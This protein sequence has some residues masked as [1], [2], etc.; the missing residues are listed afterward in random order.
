MWAR[1]Y[2]LF[3]RLGLLAAF[4]LAGCDA[5]V[6][7]ELT[8]PVFEVEAGERVAVALLLPLGAEEE[9]WRRAANDM[10]AAAELALFQLNQPRLALLVKNS[11]GEAAQARLAAREALDEGAQFIIGPVL[12]P[13][14]AAVRQ[15]V[16]GR[17]PV[18]ALSGNRQAGEGL[19]LLGF[20]PEQEIARIISF[21]AQKEA[22][23]FAGFLPRTA[24]GRLARQSMVAA[25]R[26]Q[27]EVIAVL[28]TYPPE[29]EAA[30]PSARRLAD[31]DRRTENLAREQKRLQQAVDWRG[32]PVSVRPS[33]GRS[34]VA[35]LHL[36]VMS[37]N[38]AKEQI[39][40]L[41]EIRTRGDLPYR[42]VFLPE[43]G[44][45]LRS[46]AQLL[47]FFE[48]SP[49]AVKLLGTGL[50]DDKEL[51]RERA[52][53]GGWFAAPAA[54]AS[55]RGA[56]AGRAR[57]ASLAY[58]AILLVGASLR[59]H[60]AAPDAVFLLREEGFSG[61]DGLLR[62]SP[63]GWAERGLVV[64]EA[65]AARDAPL[66]EPVLPPSGAILP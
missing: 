12:A 54:D 43:G 10:L 40:D 8:A 9:K 56:L 66:S 64:L 50:W 1:N 63:Q 47:P 11:G 17:V 26:A 59:Q 2:S 44:D 22:V 36:P 46:V 30:I 49:D 31:Y 16:A 58:D 19:F 21:A 5:E 62:F 41:R 7:R 53:A 38:E 37:A 23:P 52:L 39:E 27:G 33:R 15:E 28:E 61:V 34:S 60:G 35:P 57:I 32:A 24:Y 14:L 51:V 45:L 48:I 55:L 18:L 3:Y 13:A 20:S 4:L 65:G 42:A 25:A 29:V 6:R